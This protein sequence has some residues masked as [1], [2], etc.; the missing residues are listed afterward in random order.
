M[1]ISAPIPIVDL[2]AGPGGLGEGFSSLNSGNAF[3]ILISAE[4]D[5]AA[6]STLMLR[7]YYRLLKKKNLLDDY[8]DFCNGKAKLPYGKETEKYWI[9]ASEEAQRLTLG[10][11]EDNKKLESVIKN[12]KLTS[13]KPWVLIGGPPCQAYSLVGRSRNLGKVNYRAEEDGR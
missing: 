10:D 2:F 5:H 12:A 3:K 4:M 13:N 7:A 11:P 8:Y 9:E 6:H 1:K